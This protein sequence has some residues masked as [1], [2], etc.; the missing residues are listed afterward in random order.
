MTAG[1][2]LQD[3]RKEVQRLMPETRIPEDWDV[4]QYH[5]GWSPETTVKFLR[6]ILAG[7]EY[8]KK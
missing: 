8:V 3:F 7:T 1:Y 6:M 5:Q 2:T 4:A